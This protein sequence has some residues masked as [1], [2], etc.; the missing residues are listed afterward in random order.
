MKENSIKMNQVISITN[1]SNMDRTISYIFYTHSPCSNKP[2][3]FITDFVIS[4][5]GSWT[6]AAEAVI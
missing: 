2:D 4:E 5:K 3:A 1:C 6:K